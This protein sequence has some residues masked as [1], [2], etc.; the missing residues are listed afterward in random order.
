ML[1]SIK[2]L[3]DRIEG[4]TAI[5]YALIAGLIAVAIAGTLALIGPQLDTLFQDVNSGL[6]QANDGGT[7]LP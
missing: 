7:P 4:A 2:A 6:E 3:K 1:G 5:E